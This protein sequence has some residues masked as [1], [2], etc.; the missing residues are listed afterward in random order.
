M[1]VYCH[2]TKQPLPDLSNYKQFMRLWYPVRDFLAYRE[3]QARGELSLA[4]WL[5]SIMHPQVFPVLS[6]SDPKP[7]IKDLINRL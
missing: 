7:A 6:L 3:L 2:L 1:L 4:G 5:R